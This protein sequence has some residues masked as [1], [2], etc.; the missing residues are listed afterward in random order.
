AAAEAKAKAGALGSARDLLAAAQSGTLDEV[1]QARADLL[2]AHLAFITNRGNDAPPLLLRA[3]KRLEPI[4]PRLARGAYLEA[5]SAATFAGRLAHPGGTLAQVARA[6]GAAPRPT[7]DPTAPDLLLDG[8]AAH[9]N[10]GYAAGV[11]ILRSAL[12]VFGG[13][14]STD[15]ELQW[16]WLAHG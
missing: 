1:Q 7:R 12:R 8:L 14:M 3:A 13:G 5:L 4:D 2:R 16:L 9:F 15:E 11:P 10:E 6:A